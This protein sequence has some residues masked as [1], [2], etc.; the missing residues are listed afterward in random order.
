MLPN[1]NLHNYPFKHLDLGIT[2]NSIVEKRY[3]SIRVRPNKSLIAALPP[4]TSLYPIDKI[5]R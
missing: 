1:S 3:N 5:I 2:F 4:G